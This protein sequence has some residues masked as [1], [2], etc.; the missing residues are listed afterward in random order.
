[1][2]KGWP[3]LPT[4]CRVLS[5]KSSPASE[6]L[7]VSHMSQTGKTVIPFAPLDK[8]DDQ[9][10][11]AGQSILNL[12]H[13]AAG[14]AEQDAQHALN[15]AQNLSHQLNAAEQR[16]TDLEGEVERHRE[17]ADRAEQWLHRVYTEIEG[18]L[19]RPASSRAGAR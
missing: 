8:G 16:I 15:I 1:M 4:L 5:V 10:D 3:F 13:K 11:K 19:V 18:R 14:T 17:R 7:G 9:L 12:L 6:L 2:Q